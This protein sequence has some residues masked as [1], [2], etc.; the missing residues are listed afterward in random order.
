M[1]NLVVGIFGVM[2]VATSLVYAAESPAH[3]DDE[4]RRV[5]IHSGSY[6]D[7][8]TGESD[9]LAWALTLCENDTNRMGRIIYELAHTNNARIAERMILH[10]GTYGSL[11]HLPFL[12][13]AST[14]DIA[15]MSAIT[16]ILRLSGVNEA[17]LA[18]LDRFLRE[19]RT[20]GAEKTLVCW[21]YSNWAKRPNVPQTARDDLREILMSYG[22]SNSNVS[23]QFDRLMRSVD[24][25]YQ[26]SRRRLR[27]LRS[28]SGSQMLPYQISYVTNAINELVA[29]PEA[30]L[31][32]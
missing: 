15:G 8:D 32:E 30:N 7:S 27:I 14:N 12:R 20:E 28:V 26:N 22:T 23:V 31:P 2:T 5:L 19:G 11:A 16:S 9:D 24:P 4:I 18:D 13:V 1:R 10:L 6:I 3:G 17:S 29:Y 21:S 25:T